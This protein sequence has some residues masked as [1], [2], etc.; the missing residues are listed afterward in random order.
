[1]SVN[2]SRA[3]ACAWLGIPS[4]LFLPSNHQTA[5][6]ISTVHSGVV[7][8]LKKAWKVFK[9][10]SSRVRRSTLCWSADPLLRQPEV[11]QSCL[12]VSSSHLSLCY[13]ADE[14]WSTIF[15]R[16]EMADDREGFTQFVN[17][18]IPGVGA[19]SIVF[20]SLPTQ[21]VFRHSVM[22]IKLHHV[23]NIYTTVHA[24]TAGSE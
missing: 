10:M 9:E 11:V 3:I 24:I 12:H 7:V 21:C 1:M 19:G 14:K 16:T 23:W 2:Y 22:F 8:R 18:N 17:V 6:E 4:S 5:K 20:S 15:F 13:F